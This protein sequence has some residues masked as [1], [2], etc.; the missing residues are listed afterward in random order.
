[1]IYNMKVIK[2]RL[3]RGSL[4]IYN[5]NTYLQFLEYMYLVPGHHLPE[6]LHLWFKICEVCYW[7][8]SKTPSL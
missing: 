7:V 5:M 1:M 6:T 4:L 3:I 2:S 8:E